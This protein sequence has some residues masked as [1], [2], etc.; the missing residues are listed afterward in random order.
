MAPAIATYEP[1]DPSRTVL[2]KVIADHL[3]TFLLASF[4]ADP[5]ATG[6]PAYVNVNF[7]TIA[8]RHPGPWLSASL[9]VTR[10]TKSCF[11]AFSCKRPGV[12]PVVCRSAHGQTAAHFV[13]RVI[14]WVP[15][16]QWVIRCPYPCGIGWPLHRTSPRS[17]YDHPY[18]DWAVLVH[19]CHTRCPTNQVQPGSVRL[20]NVLQCHQFEPPFPSRLS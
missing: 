20:S 10:A 17:P 8:V 12:L 9:A 5:D 6:L 19:Q 4:E 11:H 7:M 16:R 18:H 3:A 14:P 2:Y 15:T 1:R 13:E